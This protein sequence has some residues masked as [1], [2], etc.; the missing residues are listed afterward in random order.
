[1]FLNKNTQVYSN[2]QA[3]YTNSMN[4]FS[5]E[6]SIFFAGYLDLNPSSGI[7]QLED[8]VNSLIF[9]CHSW[10]I[11]NFTQIWFSG[12]IYS[13]LVETFAQKIMQYMVH[14]TEI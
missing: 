5:K 14:C 8:M 9:M 4:I 6:G 13:P 7:Y 11:Y 1:M 12:Y 3:A 10:K 2:I